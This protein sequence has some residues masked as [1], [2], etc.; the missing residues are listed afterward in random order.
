MTPKPNDDSPLRRALRLL[1]KPLWIFLG[2][3]LLIEE[4]LWDK[5][6]A[7]VARLAHALS[8]W[9]VWAAFEQ[10]LAQLSPRGALIALFLPWLV[11][12][13][14]LKLVT[15]ALL[16]Q[17]RVLAALAVSLLAKLFG[18]AVVT[19]IFTLTKPALMQVPWFE[20]LYLRITDWLARAHAWARALPAVHDV[21]ARWRAWRMRRAA[22]RF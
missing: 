5:L 20:K 3:L 12:L 13:L 11:I 2:G 10:W 21:R 14:P 15:F 17:K 19:R 7:L 1:L 9:R 8:R 4:W 16:A 6:K 22:Q 18:T